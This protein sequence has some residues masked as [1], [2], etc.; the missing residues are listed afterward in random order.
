M[1]LKID[2]NEIIKVIQENGI[3]DNLS[4][5]GSKIKK[6]LSLL[7]GCTKGNGY[8]EDGNCS[9]YNPDN[10]T[11]DDTYMYGNAEQQASMGRDTHEAF[12]NNQ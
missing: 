11:D 6:G 7:G 10:P 9:S 12:I 2:K 1:T 4:S 5:I 3:M 8:S